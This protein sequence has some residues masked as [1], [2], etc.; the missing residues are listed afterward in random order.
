MQR[1]PLCNR[2]TKVGTTTYTRYTVFGHRYLFRDFST[3]TLGGLN[4]LE[5]VLAW[6]FR[7][8]FWSISR[9]KRLSRIIG[10]LFALLLKPFSFLVSKKSIF[11]SPS[12]VYFQGRESRQR[13]KHD[14]LPTLY[15]GLQ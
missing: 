8:F 12:G 14:E 15:R 6:S 1:L 7:Y 11:D 9:N 5:V 2:C 4:G 13:I 10:F 3:I